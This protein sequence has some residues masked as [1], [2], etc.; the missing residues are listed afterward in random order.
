MVRD[1]IKAQND[2]KLV[3]NEKV[4]NDLLNESPFNKDVYKDD[5]FKIL[6]KIVMELDKHE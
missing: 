2:G 3:Y 1:S 4:K 6:V 5:V